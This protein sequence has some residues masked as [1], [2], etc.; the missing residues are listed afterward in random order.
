MNISL[1]DTRVEKFTFDQ[2]EAPLDED[3]IGL[4]YFTAFN[5]ELKN[6]FIVK[7]ELALKSKEGFS[8]FINY[9]AFFETDQEFDDTFKI[10]HFPLENAP[11][12]AYPFLRSFISTITVNAGYSPV[13]IPTVNF[14]ALAEQKAKASED[15]LSE[16]K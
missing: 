9:V 10:S 12:I 15:S 13:L 7:F 1:R 8:F 6:S 2:I 4:S 3:E 5:D 14:H 16:S 11:A